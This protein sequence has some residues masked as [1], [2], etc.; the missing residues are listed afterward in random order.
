MVPN[1]GDVV[2]PNHGDVC[3]GI[4]IP[5]GRQNMCIVAQNAAGAECVGISFYGFMQPGRLLFMVSTRQ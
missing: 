4:T 1:H 5:R 3:G 2:V